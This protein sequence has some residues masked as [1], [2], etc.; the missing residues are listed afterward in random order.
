MTIPRELGLREAGGEIYLTSQPA[1]ELASLAAAPTTL[2]NVAV[3]APVDLA[4]LRVPSGK[5]RLNLSTSQLASFELVLGNA[6]GEELVLGFDKAKNEYF[7]DRSKAG[8]TSFSP[9]FAGRHVAPR[10]ATAA[11]ADL[12]LFFD[13]ASVELF[14]DHG[15]TAMTEIFFPSQ[16]LTTMR[17]RSASGLT[18]QQVS[19]A[20]L[21]PK[22]A[23]K[24]PVIGQR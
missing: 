15:L 21:A 3:K 23:S 18:F 7:I 5:F 9:K 19:S 20:A 17:L 16:P 12:T 4:R 2:Q 24:T 1:R 13:A 10:L 6:A 11:G 14:A 22:A 8:S